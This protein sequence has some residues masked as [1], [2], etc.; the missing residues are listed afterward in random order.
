[1]GVFSF[2]FVAL[3]LCCS[4]WKELSLENGL[5]N[6]CLTCGAS[7]P[8]DSLIPN[9][10]ML[11][12]FGGSASLNTK[13]SH[14]LQKFWFRHTSLKLEKFWFCY[15][16]TSGAFKVFTL[17]QFDHENY[18]FILFWWVQL[19][20][21]LFWLINEMAQGRRICLCKQKVMEGDSVG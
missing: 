13:L 5:Q 6:S 12:S 1:M 14:I 21:L 7:V 8:S 17:F 18:D 2:C 4:G 16:C 9:Y 11:V 10:G 20:V 15:D 3:K 19:F